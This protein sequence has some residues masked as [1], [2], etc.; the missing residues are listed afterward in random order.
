MWQAECTGTDPGKEPGD[1]LAPRSR[2]QLDQRCTAYP[3]EGE[4]RS[5]HVQEITEAVTGGFAP[6]YVFTPRLVGRLACGELAIE[7]VLGAARVAQVRHGTRVEPGSTSNRDPAFDEGFV[8]VTWRDE[9][10][11][12]RAAGRYPARRSF[13]V[14]MPDLS[15]RLLVRR[16]IDQAAWLKQEITDATA[17]LISAHLHTGEPSALHRFMTHGSISE[18]LYDELETVARHRLYAREWV[19]ALTQ[20]CLARQDTGPIASWTRHA[21]NEVEAR[22]EVWLT[23]AGVNVDELH[24]RLKADTGNGAARPKRHQDL[25]S[26]KS[27]KTE[28]AAQLIDAAFTLGLVA[29][30]SQ[31]S[32][33]RARYLIRRHGLHGA[34]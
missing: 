27:M 17:R 2:D 28:T 15:D 16:G 22:A 12:G 25:L 13:E 18:S 7:P 14:C 26:R 1:T 5:P 10:G 29:G 34:A 9:R 32:S 31:A 4:R 33:R 21:V 24:D 6:Q 20:Y 3:Q 19:D 8:H 11:P 23:A 30:R